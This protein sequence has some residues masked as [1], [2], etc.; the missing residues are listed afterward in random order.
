MTCSP[1]DFKCPNEARCIPLR[2]TCDGENDCSDN[3]DEQN[4]EGN[5]L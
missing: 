5:D 1:G 2:W 4:C 3:T